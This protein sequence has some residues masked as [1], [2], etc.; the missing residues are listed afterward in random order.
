MH[1]YHLK[2]FVGA[3]ITVNHEGLKRV[4]NFFNIIP[5][6]FFFFFFFFLQKLKANCRFAFHFINFTELQG[7]LSL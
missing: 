2:E 5:V 4:P 1:C 7:F 6:F 3:T